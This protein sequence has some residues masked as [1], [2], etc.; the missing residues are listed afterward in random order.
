MICFCVFT[1]SHVCT[2]QYMYVLTFK[3]TK[4]VIPLIVTWESSFGDIDE[5]CSQNDWESVELV[6]ILPLMLQ[7][8]GKGFVNNIIQTP[9]QRHWLAQVLHLSQR[10]SLSDQSRSTFQLSITRD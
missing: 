5:I 3:Y 9:D 10:T 6:S 4:Q 7:K 1:E 8:Q 2:V